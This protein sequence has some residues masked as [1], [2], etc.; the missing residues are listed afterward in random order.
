MHRVQRFPNLT[1]NPMERLEIILIEFNTLKNL[2]GN[3]S[4]PLLDLSEQ[5]YI[6]C[7]DSKAGKR[8]E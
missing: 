8:N 7:S 2:F 3:I 5:M 6:M 4:I 1:L